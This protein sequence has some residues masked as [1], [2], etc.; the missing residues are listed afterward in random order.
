MGLVTNKPECRPFSDI[1]NGE[2]NCASGED[3]ANCSLECGG[4]VTVNP[5]E[6]GVL[7]APMYFQ[8]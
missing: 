2:V 4:I 8:V 1:C 7:E 6:S 3:E 5:G